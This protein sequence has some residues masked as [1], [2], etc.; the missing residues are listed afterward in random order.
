MIIQFFD[1][2]NLLIDSKILI[3]FSYKILIKF[4]LVFSKIIEFGY[5]ILFF[6]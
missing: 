6:Y 2:F 5:S 1:F 4:L 3:I